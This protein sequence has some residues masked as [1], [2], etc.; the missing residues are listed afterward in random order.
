MIS[1][2]VFVY[3]GLV[4]S[5]LILACDACALH[6][7]EKSKRLD[8]AG[9][10]GLQQGELLSTSLNLGPGSNQAVHSQSPSKTQQQAR[11]LHQVIPRR[12]PPRPLRY[13]AFPKDPKRYDSLF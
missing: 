2:P 1:L 6:L 3:G 11:L 7:E 9:S 10:A 5:A 12:I 13:Q 4:F 8:L